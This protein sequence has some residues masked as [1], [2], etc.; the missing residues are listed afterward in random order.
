MATSAISL[1]KPQNI[2][3]KSASSLWKFWKKA[4]IRFQVATEI[5]EAAEKKSVCTLLSVREDAVSVLY[6]LSP[7]AS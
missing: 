3:D 1:P 4:G 5:D 7:S 6:S 2:N